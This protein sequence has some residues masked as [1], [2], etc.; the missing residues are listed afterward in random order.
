MV[1][2]IDGMMRIQMKANARM[3]LPALAQK[4]AG[5]RAWRVPD[6]DAPDQNVDVQIRVFLD[7]S[8]QHRADRRTIRFLRAELNATVKVPTEDL[9][10]S[11]GKQ[12][13][14][15]EMREI[16]LCVHK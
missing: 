8:A 3:V 12:E 13:R 1:C 15:M 6:C 11:S 5:R 7:Q 2:C 4:Q 9:N 14:V 16:V 10:G